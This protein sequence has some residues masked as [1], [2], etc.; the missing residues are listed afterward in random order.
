MNKKA[1]QLA[2]TVA[3]D[4]SGKGHK[5]YVSGS[6]GP[7][8]KLPSLGH[9]SFA[10]MTKG[11]YQQVAGLVDGGVDVLQFETGQDLL[12]A[13]AALVAMFDYFVYAKRRLPIITQVTLEAPPLST[14]LVGSDISAALTV[15]SSFPID[16]IGIN[17]ATGPTEMID[18]IQ[19]LC[20]NT[21]LAVSVLPNAGLPENVNGETVY[22]LRPDELA[23]WLKYFALEQGVN[24]VGG[25]C[26]TTPSHL[27]A[28]CE[29]LSGAAP[30]KR[31]TEHM[32]ASAS[33]YTGA[34]DADNS[35]TDNNWRTHQ[36]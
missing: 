32:A 26:G 35:G 34:A 12:Q 15:L 27:K 6:I 4:Y 17:C 22:K 19:Y 9:I 1:A 16:V 20:H 18:H 28:V 7:T 3:S 29:A 25:C 5:R 14:M 33:L 31:K 36:H 10:E 21:D 2:R 23:H 13:K 8:T 24:I 11:Y 30:I